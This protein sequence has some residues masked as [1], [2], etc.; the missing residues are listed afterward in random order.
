M[1]AIPYV[2]T[3]THG[4]LNSQFHMVAPIHNSTWLPQFTIPPGFPHSQFHMVEPNSQFHMVAPIHD[5]IW[6]PQFAIQ[7]G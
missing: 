2:G 3:S 7:Y 6:L 1:K 5:S 4:C